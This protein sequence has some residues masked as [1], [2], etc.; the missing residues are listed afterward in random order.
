MSCRPKEED[1]YLHDLYAEK[2]LEPG[3]AGILTIEEA[4]YIADNLKI[5]AKLR[6]R[7][8]FRKRKRY[9]LLLIAERALPEE[10]DEGRR[11]M[12]NEKATARS[13]SNRLSTRIRVSQQ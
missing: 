2:L 7:W 8:S 11:N 6:R 5:D 4:Q 9:P 10:P 3:W 13:V 12:L 1:P